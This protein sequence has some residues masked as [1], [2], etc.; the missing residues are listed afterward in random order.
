MAERGRGPTTRSIPAPADPL[1]GQKQPVVQI[2]W[3]FPNAN[4]ICFREAIQKKKF[5]FSDFVRNTVQ[6]SHPIPIWDLIN[7]DNFEHSRPLPSH[8]KLG[9]LSLKNTQITQ[10]NTKLC[11]SNHLNFKNLEE[12]LKKNITEHMTLAQN[13]I[14]FQK[15]M[16]GS[17]SFYL[18]LSTIWIQEKGVQPPL[19][20]KLDPKLSL[21]K[22]WVQSYSLPP[23]FG[24]SPKI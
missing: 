13:K 15:I 17:A 2:E 23:F 21:Y 22:N 9:H 10:I 24:Q 1:I 3:G 20:L 7:W 4:K 8:Q 12:V 14:W 5:I 19:P 18:N 11:Q 6:P 16:S